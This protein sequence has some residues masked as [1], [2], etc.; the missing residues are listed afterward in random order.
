M[1]MIKIGMT[2]DEVIS[3]MGT[4]Y[5]AMEAKQTDEGY[6]EVIGY[7]D[8]QSGI[9]RLSLVNGK[10]AE[11]DYILPPTHRHGDSTPAGK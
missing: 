11:W 3:T 2:K 8:W 5:K 6:K 10:L 1:Q 7:V 4:T 9:Y